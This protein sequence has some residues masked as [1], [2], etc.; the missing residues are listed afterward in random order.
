MKPAL[1]AG[2]VA[3]VLLAGCHAKAPAANTPTTVN[4]AVADND[5]EANAAWTNGMA[6]YIASLPPSSVTYDLFQRASPDAWTGIPST[7][8]PAFATTR[9]TTARDAALVTYQD[10]ATWC[11]VANPERDCKGGRTLLLVAKP[12]AL[13]GAGSLGD[14][15]TPLDLTVNGRFALRDE[16]GQFG[17]AIEVRGDVKLL[18]NPLDGFQI[19]IDYREHPA[20]RR[21]LRQC[22]TI[23]VR[24]LGRSFHFTCDGLPEDI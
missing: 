18:P 21:A 1:A 4:D 19:L 14:T 16:S 15:A 17:P 6:K 11:G 20:L 7:S 3:G 2:L 23:D 9:L 5:A 10:G 22:R 8:G 12:Q 24:V 13:P